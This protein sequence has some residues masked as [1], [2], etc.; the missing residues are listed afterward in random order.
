[1]ETRTNQ[2]RLLEAEIFLI[3]LPGDPPLSQGYFCG[4]EEEV[5]DRLYKLQEGYCEGEKPVISEWTSEKSGRKF[6]ESQSDSDYGYVAKINRETYGSSIARTRNQKPPRISYQIEVNTPLDRQITDI[7]EDL[8][9]NDFFEK[10]GID[11]CLTIVKRRLMYQINRGAIT[12]G[13]GGHHIYI[14]SKD[15]EINSNFPV[16]IAIIN[17]EREFGY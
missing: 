3:G 13:R 2:V 7:A 16:R 12:V 11:K 17:F 4:T 1:M 5:R 10:Q 14:C 9:L 8:I 6:I 15:Q